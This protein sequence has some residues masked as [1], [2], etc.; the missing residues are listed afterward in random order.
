MKYIARCIVCI[1]E[2]LKKND[3]TLPLFCDQINTLC[4]AINPKFAESIFSGKD[5]SAILNRSDNG[6]LPMSDE[7]FDKTFIDK[8]KIK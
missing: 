6:R 4:L 3:L 7:I 2:Q 5:F 1:E 8:M